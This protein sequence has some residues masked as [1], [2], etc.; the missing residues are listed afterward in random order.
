MEVKKVEPNQVSKSKKT[1]LSGEVMVPIAIKPALEMEMKITDHKSA[2]K[3]LPVKYLERPNDM[4]TT[5][6]WIMTVKGK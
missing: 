1:D 3:M 5:R 4:S 6:T 2:V